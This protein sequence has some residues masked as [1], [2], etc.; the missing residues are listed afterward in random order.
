[1]KAIRPNQIQRC[2]FGGLFLFAAGAA[3]A[4]ASVP[5]LGAQHALASVPAW[6]EPNTGQLG[7]D[8]KYFSRHGS[9]TL[10]VG[11]TG[12]IF[13]NG[14]ERLAI[15]FAGAGPL[16][17]VVGIEPTGSRGSYLIGNDSRQWKRDVPHFSKVRARG[18]YPGIDVIYYQTGGQLEFD[19]LVSPGADPGRIRLS[20]TGAG[21]A[22]LDAGGNLVFANGLRQER[23]VA[24]QETPSGRAAVDARYVIAGNGDVKLKVARFDS[25]LPLVIDPVLHA[26]YL[27]GNGGEQANAIAVD[28]QGNVWVAGSSASTLNL[29]SDQNAPI[30]DKPKGKKDVFL[31][32]LRPDALGRLSLAYWTQLGGADNDEAE[33]IALDNAGLVYLAGSTS[34]T[35]FPRRGTPLQADFGGKQ[36]AFVAMIRPADSGADALWYSQVYGG[37]D[38]DAAYAVAVDAAGA[39]YLA[40]YTVSPNLPMASAAPTQAGGQGGYEGFMV[41]VVPAASSPLAFATYLGG[42]STDV[43][44]AIA[45]AA[46]GDVYLAGYTASG[47]FPVTGD[48]LQT[49]IASSA[50]AFLVRLDLNRT[51][52]DTLRYGTYLGGNGLDAVQAMR[53][54]AAGGLWLAGYTFSQDFP[55]SPNAYSSVNAGSADLF[56]TRFD[57]GKLSSPD[58]IS[59]STYVGGAGDDV[60]HGIALAPGGRVA[61]TGYTVSSDFPQIGGPAPAGLG[62]KAFLT[63]LDPA[64]SGPAALAYSSLFGGT[65][66][67]AATGVAA[68]S[69]GR[70][71]VSG[72]TTSFDFPVTDGSQKLG[73][74]GS[75]QSFIVSVAP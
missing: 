11:Q 24:Y 25:A 71:I 29:P 45:V 60:L 27:G 13:H 72:F 32:R 69:A 40:G 65:L 52:L 37:N 2:F 14:Q 66:I 64:K 57:L 41:K 46:P 19:L 73:S 50:D 74:G 5:Q 68:D 34:S 47:N 28:Q 44:T 58:A 67:D 30:Q 39:V 38:V 36:D 70:L 56:L 61:L 22:M 6:F 59:Y 35:D 7:A 43:I 49:Q 23:P 53:L 31:A 26:G 12:A 8:V 33:A 75:M 48:G 21:K 16:S 10:L 1:M 9:G 54:D 62:P 3:Y 20:F 18:I 42:S 15:E 55:L 63:V 51:G 4:A 17:R